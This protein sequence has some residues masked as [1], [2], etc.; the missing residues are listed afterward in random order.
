MPSLGA[1]SFVVS[2]IAAVA[3]GCTNLVDEQGSRVSLAGYDCVFVEP[4]EVADGVDAQDMAAPLRFHVESLLLKDDLWLKSRAPD[5]AAFA[6]SQG[7]ILPPAATTAP[8]DSAPRMRFDYSK[9]HPAARKELKAWEYGMYEKPKGTRPVRLSLEITHLDIP[10]GA[11][12]FLLGAS[13][14]V[15]CEMTVRDAERDAPLGTATLTV[16]APSGGP[17]MIGGGLVGG[18]MAAGS[19]TGGLFRMT[20]PCELADEVVKVLDRAKKHGKAD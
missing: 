8:I 2:I 19:P 4:V 1:L 16:S 3:S 10:G 14:T 9:M 12:V 6:Q 17:G 15:S 7:M 18:A 20:A 5:Y 11:R 13:P